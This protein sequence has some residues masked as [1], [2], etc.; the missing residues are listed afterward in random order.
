MTD[1]VADGGGARPSVT[2]NIRA[3]LAR[4]GVNVGTAQHWVGLAASTWDARMRQP[5]L[6]R[7]GE[8]LTLAERLD[9]PITRLVTGA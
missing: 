9:I 7:L 2:A 6:W 5:D 4:A 8:L 3:E 1:N